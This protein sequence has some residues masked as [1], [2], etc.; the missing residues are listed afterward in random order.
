MKKIIF[1]VAA[2][3]L[4]AAGGTYLKFNYAADP[5]TNFRTAAVKRSEVSSIISATGTVEPE[6][7]IDIGAQVTG[8][9][10]E[11]GPDPRGKDDSTSPDKEKYKGKSVDYC[12]PVNKG[13]LLLQIDDSVYQA[14]LKQAEANLLRSKADLEQMEAKRIQAEN[15]WKRAD[16]LLPTNAI[17]HSD[18][19]LAVANYKAAVANVAVGKAV[20][21]QNEAA[22]DMAKRNLGY[23]TII[24]PVKGVII[25]R[26]VNAGQTVVANMS[27]QSLFLLAK[28]LSKLQV[29]AQV[30][31]ADIGRISSRPGMPVKFTIDAFPNDVFHGRVEQIRLNAQQTQ[32]VVIYTVVVAFDNSDMKVLPYLTANARFEA[33]RHSD[34]LVAPNTALRWKPR[35]E[36]IAPELRDKLAPLLT[37]RSGKEDPALAKSPT[38]KTK[39]KVVKDE[40]L[41]RL[42][43]QEGGF[44][45]PI[46]VQKGLSDDSNTEISGSD[47]KEGMEVVVG[48]KT[49]DQA[50]DT[51]NPFLPKIF[52]RKPPNR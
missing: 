29:W 24:S 3:A 2:I 38:D 23:T 7:T 41:G 44:V 39:P 33:D 52:N 8:K 45:K 28:D 9:I 21:E 20:I 27:A 47:L 34:V 42:W 5:Q 49:A 36:Q 31:E 37:E 13:D 19:D 4:V 17:S 43:I 48:E 11:F 6:E 40:T 12:T 1:L 10:Q 35:I 14:Q 16:S 50:G 18:F 46:E 25:N 32:N 30:N 22:L 51:T 15:D 26:K